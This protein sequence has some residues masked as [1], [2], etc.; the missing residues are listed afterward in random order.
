VSALASVIVYHGV[1][2]CPPAEDP[3]NLLMP[4]AKFARHMAFLS[5]HRRV[6]PLDAVI[7]GV[8]SGR[9][10]V[11][12]TFDD[13][14]RSVLDEAVPALRKYGFPATC[15]VPSGFIG[16]ANGWDTFAPTDRQLPIASAD[17]LRRLEAAGVA[18]ESHGHAHRPLGELDEPELVADLTASRVALTEI[19]DRPPRFLAYP[20]GSHSALAR[21]TAEACGFEAAFSIGQRAAGPFGR[22]R[23]T[24]RPTDGM[25][26][27][28]FKT[29]GRYLAVREA[30]WV[31]RALGLVRP[32]VV[33][34]RRRG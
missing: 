18:V 28:A 12:I 29:A 26:V 17:D 13:G 1:G 7:R 9:P 30:A 2:D 32:A 21:A 22:E 24:I 4:L 33:A 25:A 3:Y 31:D 14:Y 5:E 20:Y 19:L 6:V 8:S 16:T 23:V 34:R 11:A 10:A 15:F 27:Y